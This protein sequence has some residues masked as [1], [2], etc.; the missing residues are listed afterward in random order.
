M[1]V[2][3]NEAMAGTK[4]ADALTTA[5]AYLAR[6][7]SIIPLLPGSK[8]PAIGW[9]EFRHRRMSDREAREHWSRHPDHGIGIVTGSVSRLV[10]LD[11]DAAA[12]EDPIA[13]SR[14]C[15]TGYAVSTGSGGLHLYFRHP[16]RYVPCGPTPKTGVKRLGD[17]GYVVAPPSLHPN[18]SPYLLIEDEEPGQLPA[19]V[20]QPARAPEPEPEAEPEVEDESAPEVEAAPPPAPTPASRL[21]PPAATVP[22]RKAAPAPAARNLRA[23]EVTPPPPT[24]PPPVAVAARPAEAVPTATAAEPP[25]DAIARVLSSCRSTRDRARSGEHGWL[26]PSLLPCAT[27]I[28][29]CGADPTATSLVVADLVAALVDG[30]DLFGER[31]QH[32][33]IVWYTE[34]SSGALAQL[35][36]RHPGLDRHDD[37]FVLHHHEVADVPWSERIA[38]ITLAARSQGAGLLIVDTFPRLLE[39]DPAP[40]PLQEVVDQLAATQ[41]D[42][43][44]V[45]LVH[46]S[47]S[48]DPSTVGR[49]ETVVTLYPDDEGA[50]NGTWHLVQTAI[51]TAPVER[52]ITLGPTAP[53]PGIAP[54]PAPA[55]APPRRRTTARLRPDTTTPA[56]PPPSA[57]G[58]RGPA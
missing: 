10:V 29:L 19:W 28:G 54:P 16:G 25:S 42:G 35:L 37:L 57:R 45:L 11:F 55:A 13:A 50:V 14:D 58:R 30:S 31:A 51:G 34:R 53:N 6:G 40:V 39:L 8:Q 32:T 56:V 52:A 20:T 15:P 33:R 21:E 41:R 5:L 48:P 23:P 3:I 2:P 9:N 4:P 46:R 12:A 47:E 36:R 27:L 44:A 26:V 7:W 18:G 17:G 49:L 24:A 43:L 38:G 22:A 1:L